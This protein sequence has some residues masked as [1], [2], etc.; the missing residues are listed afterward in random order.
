MNRA[1]TGIW[2]EETACAHL[3]SLGYKIIE[4]NY[5]AKCG[6][7]DIIAQKDHY[8][9]FTEVRTRAENALVS[10]LESIDLRKMRKIF[11]TACVWLSC[12][13]VDRQP[14]LDVIE[15]TASKD[16]EKAVKNLTFITNAFGSEVYNGF[17]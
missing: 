3:V 1:E 10:G 4:R 2:G 15:S 12:H 5:R 13:K 8:I 9:C 11:K 6:E 17:F 16:N 7:I 14:R